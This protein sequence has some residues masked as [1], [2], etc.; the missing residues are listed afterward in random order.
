AV[1]VKCSLQIIDGKQRYR[2]EWNEHGGPPVEQPK[3]KGFGT[4]LIQRG[5]AAETGGNVE[6]SFAE[7]GFSFS[8]DATAD[9]LR[10]E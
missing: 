5:I 7:R 4:V 9:R 6:I 8:L 3:R 2:I 1:S 10:N